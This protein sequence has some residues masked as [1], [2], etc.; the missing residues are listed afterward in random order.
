VKCL[1]DAI[2]IFDNLMWEV[3]ARACVTTTLA[4]SRLEGAPDGLNRVLRRSDL[5]GFFFDILLE[6][7]FSAL[8]SEEEPEE[9]DVSDEDVAEEEEADGSA[10]SLNISNRLES[11]LDLPFFLALEEETLR[12]A[13]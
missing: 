4:S 6:G 11:V 1:R 10:S 7:F 5:D 3:E 13:A 8:S 9:S 12:E 2:D